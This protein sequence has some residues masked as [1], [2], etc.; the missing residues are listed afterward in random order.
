MTR[1]MRSSVA[2]L[3]SIAGLG[4]G[5]GC[6]GAKHPIAMAARLGQADSFFRG[7]AR[8]PHRAQIAAPGGGDLLIA[9]AGNAHLE[10]GGA[11]ARKDQVRVRVNKARRDAAALRID[12]CVAARASFGLEFRDRSRLQRCGRLQSEARR[13]E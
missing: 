8:G 6:A 7:G 12:H 5:R 10:L 3:Q 2:A 11:V 13:W 9:G 4:F 1:N